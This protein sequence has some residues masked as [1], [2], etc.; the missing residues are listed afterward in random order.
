MKRSPN[1]ILIV[2]DTV[3]ADHLSCYGYHR[4]TTPNIDKI[5][6]EGILFENAFSTAPWSPPSHASI[7]TG[8]YPSHHKTLGRNVCLD[9]ENTTIA[10]ILRNN[11]YKTIGLTNCNL[12]WHGSGFSKG[13]QQFILPSEESFR[14]IKSKS[15]ELGYLLS[16]FVK[17]PRYSTKSL[18][19]G[20]DS[21]T[22]HTTET[23]KALL[24][25]YKSSTPF[26]FFVNFFNCHAPYNPPRP[27][28]KK[29]VEGFHEPKLY[30]MEFLLEKIF[31]TTGERAQNSDIKKLQ[32]IAGGSCVSRFSFMA[33][34]LQISEKEWEIIR[35]WYDGEIAYLDHC[36]GD[37][38]HFLRNEDLL[39]DTLIV[40]TADHGENLG[41]HGLAGHHFCLY[42]SLL[43]IPLIISYPYLFNGKEKFKSNVSSID[44]LPTIA[45]ICNIDTKMDIQG[46]SLYPFNENDVH[47]FI[48]AECGE[49]LTQIG[50]SHL[51]NAF[52]KFRS[53]LHSVDRGYKCIRDSVYKYILSGDGTTQLFEISKDPNEEKNIQ[54]ECPKKAYQL[55]RQ[56][57]KFIDIHYFGPTD[58]SRTESQRKETLDRLRAIGYA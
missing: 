2:M 47:E 50:L 57:E 36:I 27:F 34:E 42:D 3:R 19:L 29:F 55:R 28:K 45:S 16:S 4:K 8:K 21:Y 14:S 10:E 54:S 58:I 38:V 25:R 30:I 51:K 13:F 17:G 9:N 26:F 39:E 7:F 24:G 20:P 56:M 22:Y 11:G 18:I 49:S 15:S 40:I 5:A 23:I 31:Q 52:S 46:K 33:K 43:H 41:D 12:L 53:K 1:I 32:Y 37:L 48:F 6:K 35:G 44:I